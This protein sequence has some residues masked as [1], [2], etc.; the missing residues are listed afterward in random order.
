MRSSILFFVILA[1]LVISPSLRGQYR[2]HIIQPDQVDT[3]YY[4]FND[5]SCQGENCLAAGV[6]W[7]VNTTDSSF[8]IHSTDGGLTWNPIDTPPPSNAFFGSIQ[9]IDSL[10]GVAASSDGQWIIQT[11]DGWKTWVRDSDIPPSDTSQGEIFYNQISGIAFSTASDGMANIGFGSFMTTID[12]GKHWKQINFPEAAF[13]HSYGNGMFR[14]CGESDTIFTTHDNWVTI[15][16][17]IMAL[18]GPFLD[19]NL[20]IISCIFGALDTIA[21]VCVL[22]DSV[23][24]PYSVVIVTSSD[25][26]MNW[27]VLPLTPNI[28]ID[29]TAISLLGQQTSVVAGQDSLGR[30]MMSTDFG[31][32]WQADTVPIDNDEPYYWIQSVAVTGSGRVIANIVTD[33]NYLGSNLLA[34]LEPVPSSVARTVSTQANLTLYPNPATNILNIASFAQC[35][36]S[37]SAWPELRSKANRQHA[38]YFHTSTRRVF[39]KRWGEPG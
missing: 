4:G 37:R 38:G 5:V 23:G 9:Q 16:T 34:Y 31:A 24:S 10:N 18:N 15:D 11:F 27:S 3:F 17:S 36:H 8:I 19:T 12:T 32:S 26:G 39:H 28:E 35:F 21:R 25:L 14:L 30:I 22:Q 2:W 20:H 7:S 6:R 29:P 1:S 13:F 33:S